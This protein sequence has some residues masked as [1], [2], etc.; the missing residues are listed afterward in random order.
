MHTVRHAGDPEILLLLLLLR[1]P[2]TSPEEKSGVCLRDPEEEE[3]E[4][5]ANLRVLVRN[6]FEGP[7]GGGGGGKSQGLWMSSR[8]TRRI[9]LFRHVRHKAGLLVISPAPLPAPISGKCE[10][11]P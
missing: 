9:E 10:E 2:Q 1:V 7:R 6:V 4:E 8:S 11:G 5:V 3:K